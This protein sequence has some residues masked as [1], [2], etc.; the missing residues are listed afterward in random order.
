MKTPV[1]L[2]VVLA[3]V[4]SL[5]AC[6]DGSPSVPLPATPA[7]TDKSTPS[8]SKSWNGLVPKISSAQALTKRQ[9]RGLE[10]TPW[11]LLSE[12]GR[13]LLIKYVAGGGCSS[14]K[15]VRV[16]ETST[17]VEIWTA[18]KTSTGPQACSDELRLGASRI[19]LT[20]PL[21]SRSLLHA[22]ISKSWRPYIN[23]F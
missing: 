13:S 16:Q 15:G 18:V 10:S 9:T 12:D 17:S 5:T 2:V 19:T 22:P 1:S 11:Q 20:T 23:N 6:T 4:V 8:P 21:G 14:W 3:T 7:V